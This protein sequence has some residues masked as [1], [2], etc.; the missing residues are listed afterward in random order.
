MDIFYV[1]SQAVSDCFTIF[2]K[3]YIEYSF[4]PD[5][6]SCFREEDVLISD[7][8]MILISLLLDS[9]NQKNSPST[10]LSLTHLT[11]IVSAKYQLFL[12]STKSRIIPRLV[13]ASVGL[14]LLVQFDES[15]LF[16][17]TADT[18][19]PSSSLPCLTN[20]CCFRFGEK[21]TML[22][23]AKHAFSL[24]FSSKTHVREI[25]RTIYLKIYH[26]IPGKTLCFTI[27]IHEIRSNVPNSPCQLAVLMIVV[28]CP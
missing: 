4:I 20:C 16:K 10:L 11:R 12:K 28:R 27:K 3:T 18:K 15:F 25:S 5:L 9:F 6:F 2:S 21:G 24:T 7:Y 14:F 1:I 19:R 17:S 23:L 22:E 8:T 13:A 26:L